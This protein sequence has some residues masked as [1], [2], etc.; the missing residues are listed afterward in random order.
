MSSPRCRS[1]PPDWSGQAAACCYT[2]ARKQKHRCFI[3]KLPSYLDMLGSTYSLFGRGLLEAPAL[4]FVPGGEQPRAALVRKLD[5]R[6]VNGM[7]DHRGVRRV[8][9]AH[10]KLHWKQT[11]T[12]AHVSLAPICCKSG[13]DQSYRRVSGAAWTPSAFA[14]SACA[15]CSFPPP[16][17]GCLASEILGRWAACCPGQPGPA[18]SAWAETGRVARWSRADSGSTSWRGILLHSDM[19]EDRQLQTET[20]SRGAQT[21]LLLFWYA[22]KVVYWKVVFKGNASRCFSLI[23]MWRADRW[24]EKRNT[25]QRRGIKITTSWRTNG[26]LEPVSSSSSSSSVRAAE[27]LKF[28]SVPQRHPHVWDR[29]PTLGEKT[30]VGERF[31]MQTMLT[32]GFDGSPSVF[33]FNA[34]VLTIPTREQSEERVGYGAE[35]RQASR[36]LITAGT[37]SDGKPFPVSISNNNKTSGVFNTGEWLSNIKRHQKKTMQV[38]WFH[39]VVTVFYQQHSEEMGV[40]CF[41]WGPWPH[42]HHEHSTI[43]SHIPLPNL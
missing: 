41:S 36:D 7:N 27:R 17:S 28:W 21:N 24:T 13:L 33:I 32:L 26:S 29:S 18:A 42:H 37:G 40:S 9:N 12:H 3:L 10:V 11:Q 2:R 43:R 8:V 22:H 34:V 31:M 38:T 5:V 1:S 4:R 25:Q 15:R 16:I 6:L 23:K 14:S 35:P 20:E 39:T 30:L 19:S